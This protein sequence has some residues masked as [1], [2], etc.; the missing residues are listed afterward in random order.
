MARIAEDDEGMMRPRRVVG[1]LF[2]FG[3]LVAGPATAQ[4]VTLARCRAAL[5]CSIP[6]GLRYRPPDPFIVGQFGNLGQTAVSAGFHVETPLKPELDRRPVESQ[7][8][9]MDIQAVDAAVK[10]S[11]RLHPPK[12]ATRREPAPADQ[13]EREPPR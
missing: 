6:F 7:G 3:L 4:F 13:P 8:G 5:P 9:R 1:I 2:L 10:E 11:L 12:T